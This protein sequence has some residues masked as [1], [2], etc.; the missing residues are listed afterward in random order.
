MSKSLEAMNVYLCYDDGMELLVLTI[1][2]YLT[3]ALHQSG[4][5]L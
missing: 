2:K 5:A 1:N 3:I 4:T